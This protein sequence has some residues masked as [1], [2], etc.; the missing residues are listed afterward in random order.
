MNIKCKKKV[1]N[2]V[3]NQCSTTVSTNRGSVSD[4]VYLEEKFCIFDLIKC[5]K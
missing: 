1:K 3:A 4:S 2:T 5:M